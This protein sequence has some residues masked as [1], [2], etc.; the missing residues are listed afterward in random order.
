MDR[1]RVVLGSGA[2]GVINTWLL[3]GSI[4]DYIAFPSLSRLF[5]LEPIF[6]A[7]LTNCAI[8]LMMVNKSNE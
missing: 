1:N 5:E 7:D 4:Y 2:L 8:S 6:I 3:Y